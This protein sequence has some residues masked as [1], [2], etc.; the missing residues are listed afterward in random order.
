MIEDS[1]LFGV[2]VFE[3]DPTDSDISISGALIMTVKEC[4][5]SAEEHCISLMQKTTGNQLWEKAE[6]TLI[7]EVDSVGA[8]YDSGTHLHSIK[9][10]N[11]DKEEETQ[12]N[13]KVIV[14]LVANDII[15][16]QQ[17]AK[18]QQK[19]DTGDEQWCVAEGQVVAMVEGWLVKV[20]EVDNGK[21]KIVLEASPSLQRIIA[22]QKDGCCSE[23]CCSE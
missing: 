18:S 13:N 9:V 23:G 6:A 21:A 10:Y 1:K 4:K 19:E 12:I 15:D 3:V 20:E 2:E 14:Y 17:H 8:L 16:A 22:G 7:D 11:V 5:D